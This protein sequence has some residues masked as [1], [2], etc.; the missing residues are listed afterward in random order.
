MNY[1]P[2]LAKVKTKTSM[3]I[4]EEIGV[5]TTIIQAKIIMVILRDDWK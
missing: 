4:K 5:D 2:L 1:L 3:K